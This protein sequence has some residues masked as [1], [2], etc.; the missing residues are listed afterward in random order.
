MEQFDVVALG[1]VLIDFTD[2][3]ISKDGQRLYEQNPGGA[4]ANV[5]VALASLGAKAAFL[6]KVGKDTHGQYLK[7][8]LAQKGVCTKGVIEDEKYFTTL[9]FVTLNNGERSFA[10]ARK[11][12]ADTQLLSSEVDMKQLEHTRLVH[13]GSLSLTDEPSRS[14]TLEVLKRAREIGCCISYDPNYRE[15]IGRASCRERVYVLG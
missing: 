12:G 6:G 1:E 4:P 13:I 14:T 3:G 5:V 15:E 9:A 8:V 10:F 11:P 7:E 2:A